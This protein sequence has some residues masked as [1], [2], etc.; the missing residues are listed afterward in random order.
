[1]DYYELFS[2]HLYLKVNSIG[3]EIKELKTR[4][5]PHNWIWPSKEPWSRSAPVLFPIVGKLK[6]NEYIFGGRTLN[7]NQHGFARDS[8]FEAVRKSDSSILLKLQQTTKT[9]NNYPFYFDLYVQYN[10]D[11][12]RLIVSFEVK[13]RGEGCL[14]FNL[15][16]HPAFVFPNQSSATLKLCAEPLLKEYCLLEDGLVKHDFLY[17]NV[18][19]G[20]ILLTSD[21]FSRDALVFLNNDLTRVKLKNEIGNELEMRC[22]SPHFGLW[23]KDITKFICIE[24]WWGYADSPNVNGLLENKPGIQ[25][26]SQ[27]NSWLTEIEVSIKEI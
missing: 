3:A 2:E 7:L 24:P 6:N 25:C 18:S 27:D 23:T 21:I 15:G 11:C 9:L 17:S 22:S 5:S 26:L 4:R 12:E 8:Q 16:W 1:M 13:N 10:L 14:F 19:G 20:D